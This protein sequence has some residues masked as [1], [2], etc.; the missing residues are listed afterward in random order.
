MWMI[1]EKKS[2]V[3][4]IRKIP[5]EI[6]KHYE[7]W[8][9]IVEQE[10]PKGLRLIKGFHDEA[11]RGVWSG[12]RFS[13]LSKQWRVIYQVVGKVLEVYVIDINSHDYR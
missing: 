8:K 13:R 2:L 11:L 10:G 9:R 3:K 12:Y 7:I 6:L 5:I 1:Y 4:R